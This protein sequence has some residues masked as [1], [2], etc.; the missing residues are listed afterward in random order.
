MTNL[1]CPLDGS[2]TI[3]CKKDNSLTV[4]K[5]PQCYRAFI[6]ANKEILSKYQIKCAQRIFDLYSKVRKTTKLVLIMPISKI[7]LLL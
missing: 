6:E 4:Y 5:C 3:V 2:N 1:I 7:V